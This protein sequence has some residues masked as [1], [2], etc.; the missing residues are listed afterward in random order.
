[1]PLW[2]VLLRIGLLG[3]GITAMCFSKVNGNASRGLQLYILHADMYNKAVIFMNIMFQNVS[4]EILN[5]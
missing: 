3:A 5:P 1:M 4:S 2:I